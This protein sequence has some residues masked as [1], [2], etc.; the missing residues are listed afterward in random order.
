MEGTARIINLS[1]GQQVT[2]SCLGAGNYMKANG[3][4][5]NPATCAG[6]SNLQLA[7]GTQ[8]SYSQTGCFKQN[9]EVLIEQGT[10]ANGPGT[11]IR[12]GWQFGADFIPL[13]DMCHD[14]N[15]ALNYYT[16]NTVY[17]RSANADD[18]ANS[19][20]SFSQSSY[21]PGLSVNTLYTQAEQ[22]KTIAGIV[23]SDALAGQ[24]IVP[25][26]EYY[27]SRGHMAPDGDFIDAASQDA[28]YYFMNA[29]PQFQTFN[30]GNWK[31][32]INLCFNFSAD[33][34]THKILIAGGWRLAFATR[35]LLVNWI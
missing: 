19:R 30:N 34:L 15:L 17:G 14:K 6:S 28:S 5:L 20:P 13:F 10:C 12:N 31:Y 25:N 27:L 3:L 23:G 8:Y 9:K 29:A 24:Y 1:Q 4:Q 33:N 32:N 7:D 22:T 26:T 16:I 2:I 18:K 35:Q 21:Y 11:F